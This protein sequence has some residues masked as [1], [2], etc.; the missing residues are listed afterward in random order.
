MDQKAMIESLKKSLK[1]KGISYKK[2]AKMMELSKPTI[3][4]MFSKG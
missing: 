3:D 4:K 1:L 2:L